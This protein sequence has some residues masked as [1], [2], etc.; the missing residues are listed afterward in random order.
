MMYLG[1]QAVGIATAI[2]RGFPIN[3]SVDEFTVS[4]SSTDISIPHT[5][6]K[7]PDMFILIPKTNENPDQTNFDILFG[8]P[9]ASQVSDYPYRIIKQYINNS[10]TWD[11]T[12][13]IQSTGWNS[14][15]SNIGIHCNTSGFVKARDY[16]LITYKFSEE[17]T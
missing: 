15:I 4:T 6:G 9:G 13:P 17:V 1:N 2:N 5:L 8:S 12:G 14:T 11:Y 7:A 16:Y 3:M 10:G